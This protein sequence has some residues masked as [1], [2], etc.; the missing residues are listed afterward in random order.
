MVKTKN[1]KLVAWLRLQGKHPE[2]V[3][4]ISRGKAMYFFSIDEEEWGEVQRE[5]DR[6]EFLRYAQ[7]L[8]AVIDLAY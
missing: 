8:D 6:S 3:E 2:K 4:K 7:C 1:I 5:F